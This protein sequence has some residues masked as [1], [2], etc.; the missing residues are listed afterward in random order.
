MSLAS[1]SPA[2]L[3]GCPCWNGA[4]TYLQ[5]KTAQRL[6]LSA[7]RV[8]THHCAVCGHRAREETHQGN[9]LKYIET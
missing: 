2:S 1:L 6:Q 7:K 3:P 8:K 9:Y 4:R 5:S